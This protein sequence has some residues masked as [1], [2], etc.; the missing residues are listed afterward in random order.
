MCS[1]RMSPTSCKR[2]QSCSV[3]FVLR[4]HVSLV[5]HI[6][7][8]IIVSVVAGSVS[9]FL[10]SRCG[11]A[12]WMAV[13][14]DPAGLSSSLLRFSTR[15]TCVSNLVGA[16]TPS[17]RAR[18]RKDKRSCP[19]VR[20]GM[21]SKSDTSSSIS[22]A[23]AASASVMPAEDKREPTRATG[24]YPEGIADSFEIDSAVGKRHEMTRTQKQTMH[25]ITSI[26]YKTKQQPTDN[27]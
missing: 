25:Q 21:L 11:Q 26:P 27:Q 4:L 10:L 6:T 19:A 12:V 17:G 14:H 5:L 8:T 2:P 22:L 1:A 20:K 15:F 18:S 13:L 3:F 16:A 23:I 24:E 9:L 7:L